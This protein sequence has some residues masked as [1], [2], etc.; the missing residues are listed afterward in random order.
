MSLAHDT[1]SVDTSLNNARLSK[2]NHYWEI[3]A[4]ACV[5]RKEPADYRVE[6]SS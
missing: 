1:Q 4:N 3:A 2:E 5:D 6:Q